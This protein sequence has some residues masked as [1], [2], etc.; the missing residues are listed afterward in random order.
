MEK[1]FPSLYA[2]KQKRQHQKNSFIAAK[3]FSFL[4]W[5]DSFARYAPQAKQL[6]E[7]LVAN[8]DPTQAI[9]WETQIGLHL[10]ADGSGMAEILY[11]LEIKNG[12]AALREGALPPNPKLVL[13]LSVGTWAGILLRKKRLEM[14]VL[15]GKI[16][17]TGEPNEGLRLR[18]AF[19]I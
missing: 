12:K 14:A 13:I 1:T 11:S 6:T 19:K 8:F 7:Q 9:G 3:S 18:A 2:W 16:K 15:Q 17:L 5:G 4:G 10:T